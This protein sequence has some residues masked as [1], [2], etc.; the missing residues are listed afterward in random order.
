MRSLNNRPEGALGTPETA[1]PAPEKKPDA[2]TTPRKRI[3]AGI[4]AILMVL[5][6]IAYAYSIATG[7]IFL[8]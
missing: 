6:T 3:I 1:E 2:P 8:W 5:L 4:G 7:G